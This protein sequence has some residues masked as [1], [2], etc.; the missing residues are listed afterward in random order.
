MN[1]NPQIRFNQLLTNI[2]DWIELSTTY[3][4]I[5]GERF[6][7][8]GV[9]DTAGFLDSAKT[10]CSSVHDVYTFVDDVNVSP[11]IISC[12]IDTL[13]KLPNILTANQDGLNDTWEIELCEESELYIYNRWGTLIYKNSGSTLIWNPSNE[14][15]GVYYYIIK[16]NTEIK[17]G[18][19]QLMR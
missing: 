14:T 2:T 13:P 4:A 16:H 11:I 7:Y 18:F 5:G 8:I 1:P 17:S 10:G 3:Q 15:E 12:S 19:I 9:F 6:V